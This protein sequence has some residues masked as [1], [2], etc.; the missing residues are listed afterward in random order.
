MPM[1]HRFYTHHYE[2]YMDLSMFDHASEV[3]MDI[4]E[5]YNAAGGTAHAPPASRMKP[6]GL[7][8]L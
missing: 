8:F 7:S 5:Q 6:Q 1:H 4:C 2:Q 3:F